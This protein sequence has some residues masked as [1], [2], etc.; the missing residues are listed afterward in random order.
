MTG[1]R[2]TIVLLLSVNDICLE[3]CMMQIPVTT[4]GQH[5]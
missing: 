1:I 4:S 3:T 2:S 5:R